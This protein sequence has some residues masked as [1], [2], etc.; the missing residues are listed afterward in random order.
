MTLQ[1]THRGQW[2]AQGAANDTALVALLSSSGS[3]G[4]SPL[5]PGGLAEGGGAVSSPPWKKAPPLSFLAT[6]SFAL[7]SR[8]RVRPR[9]DLRHRKSHR[10]TGQVARDSGKVCRLNRL[11]KGHAGGSGPNP[12]TDNRTVLVRN[13]GHAVG[14]TPPSALST[15]FVTPWT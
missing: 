5:W 11:G 3:L 12:D 10:A 1:S 9:R 6:D 4:R 7:W 13:S 8:R 14:G 2:R 15:G